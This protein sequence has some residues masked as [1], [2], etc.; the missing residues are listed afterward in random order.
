MMHRRGSEPWQGFVLGCSMDT[1]GNTQF[2][3]AT[4]LTDT[5]DLGSGVSEHTELTLLVAT[6]TPQ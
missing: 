6:V 2:H 3:S 5:V 4:I 1:L